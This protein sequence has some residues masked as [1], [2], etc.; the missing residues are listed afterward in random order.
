MDELEGQ[1]DEIKLRLE[2]ECGFGKLPKIEVKNWLENVQTIIDEAK[3][4][5]D[6]FKKV[7]CF[8]RVHQA[9]LVDKKIQEVK[10]YHQKGTSFNSLVIDA[11]PLVGMTLPTT[12]LVGETTAKKNMEEIWGHL[13]GNEIQKIG[14]CGMGGAG[15]TTIMTHLNNRLIEENKFKHVIWVT[16]SQTIDLIKVQ[17]EIANALKQS[18]SGIEDHKI[19]VKTLLSMFEG[20]RFVLI[21]DD[22]W[23]AIR[24]EEI[25]IPEPTEENGCKLVITTRSLDVCRSMG[26]KTVQV[27]PLSEKEALVLFFEKSELDISKVST[28]KETVELMVKQCDGLPLAIVTIA[29]SLKGEEDI[30]EWRNALLELSNNKRSIKVRDDEIF[31]RLKFSYDRLK[32]ERIQHCFLYCALYPKDHDI[33]K[34]ELVDYWIA[35]GLVDEMVNL[36]ATE[37]RAHIIIKS[38]VNNCLLLE[39]TD[40]EGR[41]CVKLHLIVR[42]MALMHI[43]SKSP[44]FMVKAGMELE[45][46]PS[47]KEWKENLDK[48]S[49]MDN[50]IREIP[51]SLSPNCQILSTLLLQGN[52]LRSIPE[53]FFSHMHGLKILNLSRTE[54]ESLPN[55]ISELTNLTALLLQNC[56]RLKHVPS[57][58]R[59]QALEKLELGNTGINEVPAGME[60]LENLTSLD[61][62]CSKLHM[63]PAGIFSKLCRLQKL[64]V[65]WGLET[66]R[67]AVEEAAT[68]KKLDR[69]LAQFHHLQDF[70]CYVK[71]LNSWGRPDEYCL[72]LKPV[73]ID[74]DWK[75]INDWKLNYDVN[76]AVTLNG[77]NICG[78]EEDSIFLPKEVESL[79]II[80]C[81]DVRTMSNIPM[82]NTFERLEILRVERLRN[83]TGILLNA[84]ESSPASQ[85]P[86]LKSLP[87]GQ[88]SH[89]KVFVGR[90]LWEALLNGQ[91]S[92]LKV[93]HINE[94]PQLMKLFTSTLMWELKNLEKIEVRNCHAMEELIAVEGSPKEFLLPKLKILSL[95]D[96]PIL[97][98][99]C[100]CNGLVMVCDSLQVIDIRSCWKLKKI[101]SS[102]SKLQLGVLK[103]LEEI[104][105]RDCWKMEEIIAI[106]DVDCKKELM[107]SLPKLRKLTLNDMAELKSIINVCGGSNGVMVCDS[108]QVIDIRSCRKLKKILSSSS[109]LQLGVLKNL[110][111]IDVRDCWKMEE[112]IA[113]DD[114]DCK[115]ELMIS[116]PKLRKLALIHMTKL[117]SIINVCGG[118]NGV[119]MVCDSLQVIDIR[120]CRKLKKILSSSSKLQLGVLKNLEEI[121]VRGC[122]EMEEIIAIDDVDCK[123][124]LIFS[125]PKL[126]KLTLNDMEELKSIINVCG[127]SNGVMVCDSLQVIDIHSCRK[128][129]KILSSSSK[130][131]LGVLKN[132][133]EIDVGDCDEIEEIIAID[134]VDCK[135]ELM[136]SLPKLR[137]LTIFKMPE[138]K[139]II[140]VCGGS[141]GVLMVCD[142]LQVIDIQFCWKLKKILSS[143]SKL[144]LG[145]LKNLKEIDVRDC[146]KMEEIIAIDDVDCK[147][148]LM[149][150][151]PKLRKLTLNDMAELKSIINVCGGSNGVMVCDSL[152]VI[153]IRSCR[154]LKK[155]L[156]SSSKLQLGVLKNLEE[157]DVR[158]CWKME[159]I[160]AIDDVDCKK[161][162]MISLPKLRKLALIHMTKLKSII[163]V[164]GGSNG[165]LMVCD[166]LQVIDIR[167]CPE[168][169]RFPI[170]LPID[171][172]GEPSPP[173][174]LIEI[175]VTKKWWKAL[176]WDHLHPRAKTLLLPFCKFD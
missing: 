19:R 98:S 58:A 129:K 16:V 27:K 88:Y 69:L 126:R 171:E 153:D 53:S 138:L 44:L 176:E 95:F 174:A 165:V 102:S 170:Y 85:N 50:L 36:Q 172:K 4:I 10:E 158:D 148:E 117:K 93:V 122:L 111:E 137:K 147:K 31:V 114:V 65:N 152:Q 5:E 149:I 159:E 78:S 79:V 73:V 115:K 45:E 2:I 63:I 83:L 132:L 66:L 87:A 82:F 96:M 75:S 41:S 145:V 135:K 105:V 108:L 106:D 101:L 8:S 24:L 162:L 107:I 123:K 48:V 35:E 80:D 97:K 39:S 25:G 121:D 134:D 61:L 128:L 17:D 92:H 9:K 72:F 14:V 18:L 29:S 139:S 142:S 70:N 130:L 173:P 38:L 22:M 146:W 116:L 46:L 30:R 94:C 113:I 81:G 11:P 6:T 60:M 125:L 90:E 57:L 21:L 140:N 133:E 161:E 77:C 37:D 23:E 71:Y 59:L 103:N 49:L 43:T 143:S 119:L 52:P 99:I 34:N 167:R 7:K 109:K 151:L 32:D 154:K 141:N 127:G 112:I 74:N 20:K 84:P 163:N 155:I 1:K 136:I 110:E 26:C 56:S 156:S 33:P 175:N 86:H 15:K 54:I 64:R 160:I 91:Y 164:C 157:I 3:N 124:E 131:Q 150:S 12:G 40:S 67:V 100:S 104:D 62:L 47:G 51:S 28:L 169:K 55:S 68:L 166:S 89:L 168:L 13:I 144:Q 118:S 76:K 42:D 120:S